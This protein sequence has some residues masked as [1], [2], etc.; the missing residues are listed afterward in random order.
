[1]EI[2]WRFFINFRN[3]PRKL[4]DMEVKKTTTM[5][6]FSRDKVV[7]ISTGK[8]ERNCVDG[9]AAVLTLSGFLKQFALMNVSGA[10]SDKEIAEEKWIF[11]R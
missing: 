9:T 7:Y 1:M 2:L 11:S 3:D 8:M 5:P 10:I 4:T 6:V